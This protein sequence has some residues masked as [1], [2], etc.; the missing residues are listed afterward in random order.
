MENKLPSIQQ[1]MTASWA[2]GWINAQVANMFQ[3]WPELND[4]G[5]ID[6]EVMVINYIMTGCPYQK[7]EED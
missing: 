5:P 4:G 6:P 3:E 1:F 2:E 7:D